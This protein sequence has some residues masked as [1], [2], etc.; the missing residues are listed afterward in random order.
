ML[1]QFNCTFTRIIAVC[2]LTSSRLFPYRNAYIFFFSCEGGKTEPSCYGGWTI[3]KT[4]HFLTLLEAGGSEQGELFETFLNNLP[5]FFLLPPLHLH[6]SLSSAYGL[7]LQNSH[8]ASHNINICTPCLTGYRSRSGQLFLH[9]LLLSVG[10]IAVTA[11]RKLK[12]NKAKSLCPSPPWAHMQL[13]FGSRQCV[14]TSSK[15]QAHPAW[16]AARDTEWTGT[17]AEHL[18]FGGPTQPEPLKELK[19]LKAGRMKGWEGRSLVAQYSVIT[20]NIMAQKRCKG[21]KI[22]SEDSY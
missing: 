8:V 9:S 21:N 11:H 17:K 19:G 6:R 22:I 18:H 5:L 20:L 4:T 3:F 10:L 1:P 7:W 16:T 2:S 12:E 15:Q 13:R 14:E